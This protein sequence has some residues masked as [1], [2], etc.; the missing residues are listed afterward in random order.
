[1]QTYCAEFTR[2]TH[3]P[4]IFEAEDSLPELPDAY[5]ITLYRTLQEALTNVIKHAHAS[6]VWVD[7]SMDD[8]QV[9]LTIQDNGIGFGEEKPGSNGIGLAG[10]RERITIAGGILAVSS[11]LKRGTILSAQFPWPSN[12]PLGEPT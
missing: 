5:N 1:M 6:Q 3:L 4:V 7:L 9:T 10:L 12:V 8:D 11:T 2:R